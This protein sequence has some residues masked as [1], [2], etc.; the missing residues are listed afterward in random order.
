MKISVDLE[1]IKLI[2]G[3]ADKLLLEINTEK[4][5]AKLLNLQLQIEEAIVNAQKLIEEA[6]LKLNPNFKS[7]EGDLIKASYRAYGQKY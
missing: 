6:G 5:L 7:V 4:E 3:K 2:A 1:E